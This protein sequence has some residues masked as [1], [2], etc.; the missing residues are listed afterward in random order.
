MQPFW[1]M[2]FPSPAATAATNPRASAS[3]Q[4][5]STY[6]SLGDQ[7]S[8]HMFTPPSLPGHEQE[9]RT[10]LGTVP[11]GAQP[12]DSSSYRRGS[13]ND[14]TMPSH[15]VIMLEGQ[16]VHSSTPPLTT[17]PPGWPQAP[18]GTHAMARNS[19]IASTQPPTS[20]PFLGPSPNFTYQQQQQQQP[21]PHISP[22]SD[23]FAHLLYPQPLFL[24]EPTRPSPPSTLPTTSIR[25]NPNTNSRWTMPTM[26]PQASQSLTPIWDEDFP[27]P[28]ATTTAQQQQDGMVTSS[29]PSTSMA[30]HHS[31]ANMTSYGLPTASPPV[32]GTTTSHA[33]P[34]S[35]HP[36]TPLVQNYNHNITPPQQ[37]I[38]SG[39]PLNSASQAYPTPQGEQQECSPTPIGHGVQQFGAL[40]DQFPAW[41][42]SEEG[43]G[44]VLSNAAAVAAGGRSQ[45]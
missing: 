16:V 2:L 19:M 36:Y 18:Q 22:S 26:D 27:W 25:T 11:E 4:G 39:L 44:F 21:P 29:M 30:A 7:D 38:H 12:N 24:P 45:G 35:S 33:Q 6:G 20:H 8:R 37:I 28:I 14:S 13:D 23:D 34:L 32:P 41:M 9:S 42:L 40:G 10:T 31:Q 15:P 3:E 17:L 1:H 43:R 5:D